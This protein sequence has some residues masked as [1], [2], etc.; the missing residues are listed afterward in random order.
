[1]PCLDT[2]ASLH[3]VDEKT[4]RVLDKVHLPVLYI[5]L[6]F[7]FQRLYKE[8]RRRDADTNFQLKGRYFSPRFV[9]Y[10][11]RKQRR[12]AV[13][14]LKQAEINRRKYNRYNEQYKHQQILTE[15]SGTNT[16]LRTTIDTEQQ[17]K[18]KSKHRKSTFNA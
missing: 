8:E 12:V 7:M 15:E 9:C 3:I 6:H 14:Q 18:T 16:T 1:M 2:V 17:D 11:A 10:D 4:E 13:Y 5:F